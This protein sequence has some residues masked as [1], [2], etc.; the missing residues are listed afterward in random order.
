MMTSVRTTV[1]LEPDVEKL[2]RRAVRER[3][4]S[5]KV[6]LNAAIRRGL[7]HREK[8]KRFRQ[9]TFG[10]GAPAPAVDLTKALALAAGLEDSEIIRKIEAGK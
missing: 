1:T 9:Q 8:P 10:M 4:Q 2:L 5:F 6:V 3:D 7:S